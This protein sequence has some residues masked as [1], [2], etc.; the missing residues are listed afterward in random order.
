MGSSAGESALCRDLSE[1]N[2]RER[3]VLAKC[4]TRWSKVRMDKIFYSDESNICLTHNGI[5]YV[6]KIL[7]R[8]LQRNQIPESFKGSSSLRLD[9]DF[10]LRRPINKMDVIK[11]LDKRGIL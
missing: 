9:D 3:F 4:Y 6:P 2:M 8:G 5:Q 1:K 10:L 11:V 7:L